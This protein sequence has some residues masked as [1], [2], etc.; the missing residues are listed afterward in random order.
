MNGWV[1]PL[2]AS[3]PYATLGHV[4]AALELLEQVQSGLL[5]QPKRIY[6]PFATGGSV[7]GLLIGLALSGSA[8]RVVAVQAVE[9]VIAN[10]RRLEG[11]VRRTLVLLKMDAA[12]NH[13]LGRLEL[14][15]GRYLGRGYHDVPRATAAAVSAASELGL[16][17]E[18]AFSGK[19]MAALL[20]ALPQ[21]GHG[22][23]LFWNTHDQQHALGESKIEPG[24]NPI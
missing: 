12:F 8:T 1:V 10:H 2:G 24:S 7:A 18:P 14:I 20:D 17:L 6:L 3:T 15:D 11:L 9:S 21:H 19:A 4:R 5:P 13:C 16:H 22:E 23:L